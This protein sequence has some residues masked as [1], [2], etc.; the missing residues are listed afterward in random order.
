M[1]MHTHTHTDAEVWTLCIE[2]LGR[3]KE[4]CSV[5]DLQHTDLTE[6]HEE[7]NPPFINKETESWTFKLAHIPASGR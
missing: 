7:L 3:S 5:S 6:T 1:G 4:I 2:Y